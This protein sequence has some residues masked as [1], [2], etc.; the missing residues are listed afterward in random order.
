MIDEGSVAA[1][2][3]LQIRD[4][5]VCV[6]GIN[7]F[8]FQCKGCVLI[9]LGLNL[10]DETSRDPNL[11]EDFINTKERVTLTVIPATTILLKRKSTTRLL[12]QNSKNAYFFVI[13]V[14]II[15]VAD[16]GM[17]GKVVRNSSRPHIRVPQTET[18]ARSDSQSTF[19][20]K[21]THSSTITRQQSIGYNPNA[22]PC[23]IIDIGSSAIRVGYST[24]LIPSSFSVIELFRDE[25][26]SLLVSTAD[27]SL[28]FPKIDKSALDLL[29]FNGKNPQEKIV[30]LLKHALSKL[31][32][33]AAINDV[34]VIHDSFSNENWAFQMLLGEVRPKLFVTF[35]LC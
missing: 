8:L 18:S 16:A 11:A 34:L 9:I 3:G 23:I 15:I 21:S 22:A 32:V 33:E 7:F 35:L 31:P 1:S 2:S 12:S 25:F 27:G 29:I 10:D 26:V 17:L 14:L 4:V 24:Q 20:R 28:P 30:K 5:I 6:D 13:R 19:S